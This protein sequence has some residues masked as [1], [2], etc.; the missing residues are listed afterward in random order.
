MH[1]V[2]RQ[3]ARKTF[4]DLRARNALIDNPKSADIRY[5][6]DFIVKKSVFSSYFK[7][8]GI[9]R[10]CQIKRSFEYIKSYRFFEMVY[11]LYCITWA[12]KVL[13]YENAT[14]ILEPVLYFTRDKDELW[15]NIRGLRQEFKDM[16]SSVKE[17]RLISMG[18]SKTYKESKYWDTIRLQR[19]IEMPEDDLMLACDIANPSEMPAIAIACR[20]RNLMDNEHVKNFLFANEYNIAEWFSRNAAWRCYLA[21][22]H[23]VAI[24]EDENGFNAV[25]KYYAADG[26]VESITGGISHKDLNILAM[27]YQRACSRAIDCMLNVKTLDNTELED[28]L[29]TLANIRDRN[30]WAVTHTTHMEDDLFLVGDMTAA[31]IPEQIKALAQKLSKIHGPVSIS[32]EASGRHLYIADPELLETDGE[33]E[34][35]SRH[36][37]I[38]VDKYFGLGQWNI[39][40]NPTRENRKL[41]KEFRSQNKEVPCAMSMKTGRTTTVQYLASMPPIEQRIVTNRVI[42]KKVI[43]GTQDKH[44]VYDEQGNLVPEGPGDLVPLSELPPNHPALEY[45]KQRG[46]DPTLLERQYD[47]KYCVKALPE[48][49]SV[50]RYW[51]KLPAGCKNSPQGRIIFPIVD[52]NGVRRGWQARA[53]DYKDAN[54]N[55]Y[56]WTDSQKWLQ[57]ESAGEPLHCSE[58]FPDGFKTLRK[59]INARGFNRNSAPFGI[60]QAVELTRD[61]PYNK[62][63]CFLMEGAMDAAKGGPPCIALLGKNMSEEQ[64]SIIRSHFSQVVIVADQDRAGKDFIKSVSRRLPELHIKEAILPDGKKDLGECTYDEAYAVLRSAL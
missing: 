20:I 13:K 28:Y 33:K 60:L 35:S 59:Y 45:L 16:I 14:T 10:G 2:I 3:M 6:A 47:V 51:S 49:R 44:L 63:V 26:W 11:N 32:S 24:L 61:I 46:Y 30:K 9:T 41:Y 53:I 58:K 34:L 57:I 52:I 12:K 19:Y 42:E 50:G 37:A 62:R 17:A 31:D 64:A 1:P 36:M 43:A 25:T 7:A 21:L 4:D 55:R 27:Q 29:C 39:D 18:R 22:F 48:D 38:N 15:K 40:D 54:G 8:M 5:T 56:L 23:N